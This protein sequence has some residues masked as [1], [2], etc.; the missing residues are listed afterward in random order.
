MTPCY[1][2]IQLRRSGS[3]GHPVTPCRWPLE[4]ASCARRA[5]GALPQRH[6][7]RLHLVNIHH[8]DIAAVAVRCGQRSQETLVPQSR[9]CFVIRKLR[10]STESQQVQEISSLEAR[11]KVGRQGELP[12][13]EFVCRCGEF[14]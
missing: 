4:L 6:V 2:L 7:S 14:A 13:G 12:R 5:A 3:H 8:L 9:T 1:A 11:E 10:S